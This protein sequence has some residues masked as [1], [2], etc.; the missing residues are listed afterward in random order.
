MRRRAGER[1]VPIGR[2]RESRA[3][4][5]RDRD[6]LTSQRRVRMMR[7]QPC[8]LVAG[9]RIRRGR[10]CIDGRVPEVGQRRE[11]PE[12]TRPGKKKRPDSRF[13][14]SFPGYPPTGTPLARCAGMTQSQLRDQSSRAIR[15]GNDNRFA[16]GDQFCN[17]EKTLKEFQVSS[18]KGPLDPNCLGEERTHPPT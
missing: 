3:K 13:A 2:R 5:F 18:R 15:R 9:G 1:A 12:W 7:R 8:I 17:N 16:R 6:Q 14:A 10:E 11:R 4:P